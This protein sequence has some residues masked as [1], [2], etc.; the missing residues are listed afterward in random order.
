MPCTYNVLLILD[1]QVHHQCHPSSQ[2]ALHSTKIQFP[3]AYT[4]AFSPCDKL[5][6][7]PVLVSD[8]P[9]L[10]AHIPFNYNTES[11]TAA[12]PVSEVVVA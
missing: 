7:L 2:L 12:P 3:L 9:L 10:H 11:Q 5:H 1:L 4:I 8:I 6:P